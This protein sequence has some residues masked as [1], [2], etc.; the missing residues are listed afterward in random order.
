MLSPCVVEFPNIPKINANPDSKNI[1]TVITLMIVSQYSIS[2][3]IF[4][5]AI[6]IDN[7]EK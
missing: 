7:N 3:N 2:P 4:T 5:L 6:F 1:I